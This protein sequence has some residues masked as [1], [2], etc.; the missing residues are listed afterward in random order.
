MVVRQ[1]LPLILRT[2]QTINE[3][4]AGPMKIL[5]CSNTTLIFLLFSLDYV[6]Y[7]RCF[8]LLLLMVY[9]GSSDY[10]TIHSYLVTTVKYIW[11]SCGLHIISY[12]LDRKIDMEEY[13]AQQ[14][15]LANEIVLHFPCFHSDAA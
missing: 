13:L 7:E 6:L 10:M 14:D 11:Q 3:F 12:I 5:G 8:L 2:L 4:A 9:Y 1:L 15:C